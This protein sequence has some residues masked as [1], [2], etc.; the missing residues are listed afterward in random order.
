MG[1]KKKGYGQECQSA[2]KALLADLQCC[3]FAPDFWHGSFC[4]SVYF[5]HLCINLKSVFT[6]QHSEVARSAFNWLCI[7]TAVKLSISIAL[8]C[9]IFYKAIHIHI[10]QQSG[11]TP[12]PPGRSVFQIIQGLKD[13]LFR[14]HIRSSQAR[15]PKWTNP[16]Q[17]IPIRY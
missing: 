1:F 6:C 16:Y 2:H 3:S 8:Q 17:Q 9:H 5:R 4:V 7:H 15:T 10:F 11:F 12:L 13:A 14:D